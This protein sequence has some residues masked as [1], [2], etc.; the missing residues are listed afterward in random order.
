MSFNLNS[1]TLAGNLT[2]DPETRNLP[3]DQIVVNFG[4]A[5]NRRWKGQDG[6]FKEE[7]T[8]IDIEAWGRTGE[9][10]GQYLTK[11]SPVYVEGRLKLDQWQDKE[12][13]KRSKLKVVANTVQFLP[14]NRNRGAAGE[15]GAAGD[16]ASDAV[17]VAVGAPAGASRAPAQAKPGRGQRASEP[18]GAYTGSDLTDQ[19]PF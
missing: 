16:A 13:Q 19:P 5:V 9:L 6:E 7:T 8:F 12:N 15:A 14:S 18:A 10:V 11:G 3:N 17:A 4:M 2:R 1:V